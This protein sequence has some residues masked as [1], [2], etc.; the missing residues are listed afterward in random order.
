[1]KLVKQLL[2][3]SMA[4]IMT[5][6][7]MPVS[8]MA[9]TKSHKDFKFE[10]KSFT[11]E[12]ENVGDISNLIE[13]G[14]FIYDSDE[15]D[16]KS[17]KFTSSDTS[18]L[19]VENDGT[20]EAISE[21]TVKITA[22][23]DVSET[24]I[25]K[26]TSSEIDE[27]E[28]TSSEIDETKATSSEVDETIATSSEI[29]ETKATSSEIDKTKATPSTIDVYKATATVT[30][31]IT[32][33]KGTSS[34]VRPGKGTSSEIKPG[35]SK[36]DDITPD[37]ESSADEIIMPTLNGFVEEGNGNVYYYINGQMVINTFVDIFDETFYFGS[38]GVMVADK[39]ILLDGYFYQFD[40]DGVLIKKWKDSSSSSTSKKSSSSS[41]GSSSS[42]S[43]GS[44]GKSGTTTTSP[45]GATVTANTSTGA[46][47][48]KITSSNIAI[49]GRTLTVEQKEMTL[50]NGSKQVTYNYGGDIAGLTFNG[51][52]TVAAD[53][54]SITLSN[55]L[56]YPVL[57]SPMLV[58]TNADGTTMGC[59]TDPMTGNPI[60]TGTDMVY[61][62]LGA[63][64]QMHAHWVNPAGFFYTGVV[65][66]N[67]FTIT[68][69][70]TG[71]M[72]SV[73]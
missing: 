37:K 8:S 68:F 7:Q 14:Y 41:G 36:S 65:I 71:E 48:S 52:G 5:I 26:A 9:K 73:S 70:E 55:G 51:V 53:G 44:S 34:E 72:I 46:D 17:I 22:T 58:I 38:D 40:E 49:G 43:S 45:S 15:F 25:D 57:T 33:E 31:K 19:T 1:M 20:I 18:I 42:S 39:T 21:G 27:T 32:G 54:K 35:E 3:L 69:S 64:G 50:P 67:G 6:A 63:D 13:E 30:V 60:A 62:C 59:F 11:V 24:E 10:R 12:F 66:M 16:D 56:T 23:I 4:G 61:M 29:D 47:G 28:A 2:C